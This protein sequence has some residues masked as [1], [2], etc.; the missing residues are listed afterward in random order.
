MQLFFCQHTQAWDECIQQVVCQ[1]THRHEMSGHKI[2]FCQHT[3]TAMKWVD[4]TAS[5]SVN[6]HTCMKWVDTTACCSVSQHTQ[7]HETSEHNRLLFCEHMHEMRLFCTN[8]SEIRHIQ[9][10][11]VFRTVLETHLFRLVFKR[12]CHVFHSILL[13][14]SASGFVCVCDEFVCV[15]V[16][17]WLLPQYNLQD[18]NSPYHCKFLLFFNTWHLSRGEAQSTKKLCC[19]RAGHK[20]GVKGRRCLLVLVTPAAPLLTPTQSSFSQNLVSL[21]A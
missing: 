5:C 20:S 1:H 8:M 15:L 12:T 11:T 21:D 9:L 18:L 14:Y 4:T 3:H 13:A 17:A 19:C 2:L 16:F 6:R 10:T 7:R